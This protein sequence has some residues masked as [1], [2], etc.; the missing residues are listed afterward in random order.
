MFSLIIR[1]IDQHRWQVKALLLG[2]VLIYLVVVGSWYEESY[3]MFE[4]TNGS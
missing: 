4:G 2:L 1:F 3:R